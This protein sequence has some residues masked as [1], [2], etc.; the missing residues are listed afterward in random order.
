LVSLLAPLLL[1]ALL[2]LA[3][4]VHLARALLIL[5]T[6]RMAILAHLAVLVAAAAALPILG[7]RIFSW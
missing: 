1:L 6:V 4:L 3:L 7:H 5:L 2:G